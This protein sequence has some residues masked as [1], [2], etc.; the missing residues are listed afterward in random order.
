MEQHK[1]KICLDINHLKLILLNH[2][3]TDFVKL[4]KSIY[5]SKINKMKN[6]ILTLVVS[7][8]IGATIL[9]GCQSS[10][11]KVENAQENLQDAQNNLVEADQELS[12]E[13]KDSIQQFKKESDDRIAIQEQNLA[14]FKSRIATEKKENRDKYLE[15]LAELEQKNTDMKKRLADLNVDSKDNWESFKTKFSE[16]MD[17]LGDAIKNMTSKNTKSDKK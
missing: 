3:F 5:T 16:D 6:T 4:F 11:K 2:L 8:F 17:N 9:S 12:K 1:K 15:K 14:E 13:M 10:A 7:A